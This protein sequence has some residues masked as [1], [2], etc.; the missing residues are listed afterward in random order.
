[1]IGKMKP[2][3]VVGAALAV[4]LTGGCGVGNAM[5]MVFHPSTPLS[6]SAS[7]E[8][9]H[10]EAR[11]AAIYQT[12]DSRGSKA[13]AAQPKVASRPPA[14]KNVDIVGRWDGKLDLPKTAKDDPMAQMAG[15]MAKMFLGSL[16]LEFR[17]D[18]T[19][20]LNI[21]VPIEGTYT[22]VGRNL[23]LTPKT[24]AG[25]TEAEAIKLGKAEGKTPREIKALK[26]TISANGATISLQGDAQH[27]GDLQF[28]RAAP[29]KPVVPSVN[30]AER[31][32]VGHWKGDV[33]MQPS[34]S[35][36]AA[37]KEKAQMA[38]RM[39]KATLELQLRAD[40]TFKM[41]M[42]MELE[43][44]WSVK[45]GK[46]VLKVTGL[47]GMGPPTSGTSEPLELIISE[48]GNTLT[49]SKKDADGTES[50]TF[51]RG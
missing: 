8:A 19:F 11:A 12:D 15:S 23:T 40:N 5:D 44:R 29:E 7:P 22:R 35:A 30:A 46:V 50:L 4:V 17:P 25:L 16:S 36:S 2:Y 28:R 1:M 13:V 24:M 26:G 51:R 20:T 42:V 18:S 32:F 47:A 48:G 31:P 34:P 14:G 21:M 9:P 43:G 41:R 3:H 27:K 37:D 49:A 33:D 10:M 38:E 6:S 39:L 45:G